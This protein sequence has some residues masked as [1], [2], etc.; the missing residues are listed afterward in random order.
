MPPHIVLAPGNTSRLTGSTEQT[1]RLIGE[2]LFGRGNRHE[3]VFLP[4]C[5]FLPEFSPR[6]VVLRQILTRYCNN[7][8]WHVDKHDGQD[9][10]GHLVKHIAKQVHYLVL[11]LPRKRRDD[12]QRK[13]FEDAF[14]G[15]GLRGVLCH[16]DR[17]QALVAVRISG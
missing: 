4:Y 13:P 7:L 17:N 16:A 15:C 8:L 14:E 12:M 1:L 5:L 2:Y 11:I 9:L 6:F 3:M 10:V